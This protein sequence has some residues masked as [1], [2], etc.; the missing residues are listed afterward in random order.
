V[1]VEALTYIIRNYHDGGVEEKND[2]CRRRRTTTIQSWEEGEGTLSQGN[3]H[4]YIY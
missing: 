2:V 1:R 3:I 4:N